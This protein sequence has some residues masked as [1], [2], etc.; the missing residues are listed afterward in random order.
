MFLDIFESRIK[1]Q[2]FI[3]DK[4]IMSVVSDRKKADKGPL[5][6]QT[7]IAKITNN[8]KLPKIFSRFYSKGLNK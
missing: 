2:N 1:N 6:T 8:M 3:L 5:K 4:T 7:N